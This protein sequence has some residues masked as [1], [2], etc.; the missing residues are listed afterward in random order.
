MWRSSH[1]SQATLAVTPVSKTATLSSPLRG[2]PK[3]D[4]AGIEKD[5]SQVASVTSWCASER[6]EKTEG[7]GGARE[8]AFA[9]G[10]K[11]FAP[12]LRSALRRR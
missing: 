6:R 11:G 10:W 12:V 3:R 9:G 7:L 5:L 8:G 4:S 2:T 1:W